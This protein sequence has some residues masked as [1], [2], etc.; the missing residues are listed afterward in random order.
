MNYTKTDLQLYMS[1]I[2]YTLSDI[3]E[4]LKNETNEEIRVCL[5]K[6]KVEEEKKYLEYQSY[7]DNG[8]YMDE[9]DNDYE[10]Y[11]NKYKMSVSNYCIES[12]YD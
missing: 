5:L 2:A 11:E 4:Q 12:Y 6:K 10:Y 9:E 7:L 1:A 8:Y 3:E